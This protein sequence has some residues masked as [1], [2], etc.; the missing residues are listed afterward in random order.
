MKKK[1]KTTRVKISSECLEI[2]DLMKRFSF[3]EELQ[4][5]LGKI[6]GNQETNKKNEAGD[7]QLSSG[8]DELLSKEQVKPAR[9]FEI[10]SQ[11][12]Q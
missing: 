4:Q 2:N 5:E 3:E 10:P 12:S 6:L 1:G 9:K 8:M 11:V 7:R